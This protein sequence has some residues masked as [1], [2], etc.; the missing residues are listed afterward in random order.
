LGQKLSG[1]VLLS[2]SVGNLIK[3]EKFMVSLKAKKSKKILSLFLAVV[4]ILTVFPAAGLTAFAEGA[5]STPLVS[6]V[7]LRND[8]T[9]GNSASGITVKSQSSGT[10]TYAAFAYNTANLA[11]V[12][13]DEF[14]GSATLSGNI[15]YANTDAAI[16]NLSVE[17]HMVP[18][19]Y[20][21]PESNKAYA[22]GYFGGNNYLG[23]NGIF[24]LG[25]SSPCPIGTASATNNP[26]TTVCGYMN[27]SA[28]TLVG[29]VSH[30]QTSYSFDVADKLQEVKAAGAKEVRF[31]VLQKTVNTN[32]Q[33]VSDAIVANP[34]LTVE[35]KAVSGTVTF[36]Q[37]GYGAYK[38]N[39]DDRC[40][41]AT[42]SLILTS[43]T[44]SGT[45]SYGVWKYDGLS[46]LPDDYGM[47][48][49]TATFSGSISYLNVTLTEGMSV[50]FFV[51]PDDKVKEDSEKAGSEQLVSATAPKGTNAM[52]S[53][54]ALIGSTTASNNP[55]TTIKNA[56][57]LTDADKI[58]SVPRGTTSFS[59]DISKFVQT[60]KDEGWESIYIVG[61]QEKPNT[62]ND[63]ASTQWSDATVTFPTLSVKYGIIEAPVVEGDEALNAIEDSINVY[64]HMMNAGKVYTHM[65]EAYEAFVNAR[66]AY[67]QY[68]YGGVKDT[69]IAGAKLALD[70]A[71]KNMKEVTSWKTGTAKASFAG[72]SQP[73]YELNGVNVGAV[74]SSKN[75]LYASTVTYNDYAIKAPTHSASPFTS[76]NEKCDIKIFYKPSVLLYDGK[77]TPSL[78]IMASA[79]LHNT[80]EDWYFYGA[81][82]T[83]STGSGEDNSNFM[84]E[85][86]WK[87]H[88]DVNHTN[89]NME[90]GFCHGQ[91]GWSKAGFNKNTAHISRWDAHK[92]EYYRTLGLPWSPFGGGWADHPAKFA[93]VLQFKA[94]MPADTILATYYPAWYTGA[95]K[96]S[97]NSNAHLDTTVSF[98]NKETTYQETEN[99]Y[100]GHKVPIYVLNYKAVVDKAIA[101]AARFDFFTYTENG[102]DVTYYR[103]GGLTAYI[104]AIDDIINLKPNSYFSN[105]SGNDALEAAVKNCEKAFT[106]AIAAVDAADEAK[107]ED[108]YTALRDA[109]EK[110][111]II[112]T[113][114]YGNS[115]GIYTA[116]SWADFAR[117]FENGKGVMATVV[118]DGYNMGNTITAFSD[119]MIDYYNRLETTT[120]KVDASDLAKLI[121]G[122][123]K[124]DLDIFTE[125]TRNNFINVVNT[126]KIAVWG[127]VENFGVKGMALDDS[128]EARQI[129]S[130]QILN[131]Y[132]T[133]QTLR[134]S[135]DTMVE[136]GPEEYYSLNT[137]VATQNGLDLS[138]YAGTDA[139]LAAI[140]E[141]EKYAVTAS[142]T[143]LTNY[144][145]QY[146]E[147]QDMVLKV[148]DCYKNLKKSVTT[149]TDGMI[150]SAG[151]N[152][153]ILTEMDRGVDGKDERWRV[154]FTYPT[155]AVIIR[156]E[157][158]AKSV[159]Y[160]EGTVLWG[161]NMQNTDCPGNRLDSVSLNDTAAQAFE[162]NQNRGNYFNHVKPGTMN[163]T[164][165]QQYAGNLSAGVY[166]GDALTESATINLSNVKITDIKNYSNSY[167]NVIIKSIAASPGYEVINYDNAIGYDVTSIIANQR[168]NQDAN[169]SIVSMSGNGNLTTFGEI[170]MKGDM[171]IQVPATEAKDVSKLTND[172][173]PK[174]DLYTTGTGDKTKYF[175][176]TY[177]YDFIDGSF[178]YDGWGHSHQAYESNVTVVDIA[179]LIDLI[180]AADQ[181]TDGS[182]YTAQSWADFVSK[183]ASA[184]A[185]PDYETM[186]AQVIADYF[187]NNY[188]ALLVAYKQ[189]E[190]MPVRVSFS[191]MNADGIRDSINTDKSVNATNSALTGMRYGET[192]RMYYNDKYPRIRNIIDGKD[193]PSYTADGRIY[194]FSHWDRDPKAELDNKITDNSVVYTA[195]YTSVSAPADFTDYNAKVRDLI[196]LFT[197]NVFK[198]S[199]IDRYK[200]QLDALQYF[201]M[202]EDDRA[203][204]TIEADQ[205]SVDAERDT[206]F[207]LYRTIN[208][209]KANF[210]DVDVS[211]LNASEIYKKTAELDKDIYDVDN[212]NIPEVY[213]QVTFGDSIRA[214]AYPDQ[215]GYEVTINVISYNTQ[216]EVNNKVQEILSGIQIRT[217]DVYVNN[218]KVNETSIPY[219]TS[220]QVH[221]DGEGYFITT[222]AD[223]D[224][225]AGLDKLHA[226]YYSYESPMVSRT[227]D[228]F[229]TTAKSFGFIIKG[230]AYLT[231]KEPANESTQYMVR[232]IN[233]VTGKIVAADV[234]DENGVATIPKAPSIA[235]YQFDHYE[236]AQ[237]NVITGPTITVDKNTDIKAVYT[238]VTETNY[239]I[240]VGTYQ[241]FDVI[242]EYEVVATYNQLVTISGTQLYDEG[243]LPDTAYAW[244][245]YNM[246]EDSY[247]ILY[248]GENYTFNACEDI[249]IYPIT[250]DEFFYDLNGQIVRDQ[251]Y[252]DSRT[253]AFYGT[254]VMDH[255]I[256][257]TDENGSLVKQS[258][259]GTFIVP[260]KYQVI[261]KGI[262]FK[263][264][265][266][267]DLTIEKAE[268]DTAIKRLKSSKHTA[269]NQFVINIMTNTE[270]SDVSYCSYLICKNQSGEI[271]TVYSQTV[272]L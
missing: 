224:F 200:A 81:Y 42:S 48:V 216:A 36:G 13:T 221:Q 237:G 207:K 58:G 80:R 150:L 178:W 234:T 199:D 232:L 179:S 218:T 142:E 140:E 26:Y 211:A 145:V 61:L 146:K 193:M 27:L 89:Q 186:S 153:E 24:S 261:E 181:I 204:L 174:F 158:T 168:G 12:S 240:Q 149:L 235:F 66:K 5:V 75:L 43:D 120:P 243:Y 176:G 225:E 45:Y 272:S 82:P 166:K 231:A 68:K 201:N 29:T 123:M 31:V 220:V 51:V 56:I 148:I 92:P 85:G 223:N 114:E 96:S 210:P 241:N 72:D 17:I 269:G 141:A 222:N 189:L 185:I 59:F 67:D 172:D 135:M 91:E 90:Y 98:T 77:T 116:Q 196:S 62:M 124:F 169:D 212:I 74:A 227:A 191:F 57:G 262:L 139:Y 47:R 86:I 65:P 236:D 242:P 183:R 23:T 208:N 173:G 64:K 250:S 238:P 187:K 156:T 107:T 194:T 138:K 130:D 22:D 95:A 40:D 188:D 256:N 10:Y 270:L 128:E 127:A 177:C 171:S 252:E 37:I 60:A 53:R 9:A 161:T 214:A 157:H 271:V 266:G 101:A 133:I 202:S 111:G 197:D 164:Q 251:M 259:I 253:G 195:V 264:A 206:I 34:N 21:H 263:R 97:T 121:D 8:P 247:R 33:C 104:K 170:Y 3:E 134:I 160:G 20:A 118:A 215:P 205:A 246:D 122:S 258:I 163:A 4:M 213:E 226:W 73:N 83:D 159:K 255:P 76:D 115:K 136:T 228:K 71:V 265:A 46:N 87:G 233:S 126:A 131:V 38:N 129:V 113:Y 155:E 167:R 143:P 100:E 175:G 78:P 25:D 144:S 14:V 28:D 54:T 94:Q 244:C 119:A 70:R 180:K 41:E 15:S 105:V 112:T 88:G 44:R 35:T 49:T 79:Q 18:L 11:S 260:E 132:N 151:K 182:K 209:E 7:L 184:K 190:L 32:T 84:L 257:V 245:A 147:Y 162:I 106:D 239:V 39:G 55:Y 63:S 109:F 230:D 267:E 192:L 50:G 103:E 248:Y 229:M 203:K 69:D 137:A 249:T 117:A 1:F 19:T 93:N 154:G 108:T 268:K 217:Y 52:C 16:N 152:V 30:T 219:G 102:I 99:T 125:S 6:R 198:K 254:I 110:P 165:L 2:Y